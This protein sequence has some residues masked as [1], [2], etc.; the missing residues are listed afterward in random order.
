MKEFE[1]FGPKEKQQQNLNTEQAKRQKEQNIGHA[2]MWVCFIAII[3][4]GVVGPALTGKHIRE[5]KKANIVKKTTKDYII[6]KDATDGTERAVNV[7]MFKGIRDYHFNPDDIV[8]YLLPGDTIYVSSDVYERKNI[9]DYGY[10]FYNQDSI[11]FRKGRMQI[12]QM[13]KQR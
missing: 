9:I 5:N 2:A 13:E 11:N 3:L 1:G 7:E 10:A 4:A 12:Q 6:V 8:K